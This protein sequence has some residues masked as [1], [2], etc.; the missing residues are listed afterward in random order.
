M[1]RVRWIIVSGLLA[2]GLALT[3]FYGLT[4]VDAYRGSRGIRIVQ[5]S[6]PPPQA[7]R[8]GPGGFGGG[9]GGFGGGVQ[10]DLPLVKQFDKDGDGRLNNAERQAARAYLASQGGNGRGPRGFG[11]SFPADAGPHLTPADV[12]SYPEADLYD[13]SV[14]RTIFLTFENK[15]WEDEMTAF[16]HTDVDVPAQAI[17]DGKMYPDVGVHFRGN[18]S[19]RMVPEGRKHSLTLNM[20]FVDPDQRLGDYRT[21][22]LLNS[23]QDPS[24]MKTIMYS[25]IA[26]DYISAPK[27]NFIRVV[28]N[29]ENWGIYA[30]TEVFNKDFLR[31][32]FNTTKGTRWRVPGSPRGRAGLEYFGENLGQYKRVFEIKTKDDPQAWADL[33]HL[34]KV[35]NETP[36]NRLVAALDPIL[37]IDGALRFLA[38]DNALI[39]NDGYW[40]RASDYSIFEDEKHKFHILPHDFNETVNFLERG[41]GGFGGPGFGGQSSGTGAALDP[42]IGLDDDTKPL[43][44]RLLAVPALRAK[45]LGYVHDIAQKWL[46]WKKM[47]PIAKRYQALIVADV[48]SDTHKLYGMDGFAVDGPGESMKNFA[49]ERRDYLLDYLSTRK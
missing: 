25:E 41:R 29:G 49:D 10:P 48:K 37:D 9:F 11:G 6:G 44:S 28:I 7:F 12:K 39:N 23:N 43:R 40:T 1:N 47:G 17:V 3:T 31:D 18:S 26:R 2:G 8:Q 20:D 27:A 32:Y 34:T 33:I 5:R 16:Y 21:L 38:L 15:D 46:D 4:V 36:I 24:F 13:G 35:L 45:Y 42:L 30:N 14:L 19:F 22:N